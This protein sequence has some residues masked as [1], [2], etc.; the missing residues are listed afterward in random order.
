MTIRSIV[1]II[2][3]SAVVLCF[4]GESAAKD[5]WINVRT[6][7]FN[8]IGNAGEK[9]IRQ[10]ATKLEQFHES[11]QLLFA[12][13]NFNSAIQTNVVVFKSASS[14]RPYKPKRSDGKPDDG[15]AGYFQPGE[16]VNYITLSTEGE[17]EDTYGTIFHEYVHFLLNT[18]YGKSDVP[19]WF[20]EG[21]AEYYQTFKIA[22][23]QKITLG[24]IQYGHL[25]LLQQNN[26]IPLKQFFEVDNY[27]LHHNGNHSR[28]IFYAQAWALIHYMI[29]GNGGA[30][31]DALGK[32]LTLVMKD[33]EPEKAFRLAFNLNYAEMEE[34][35]KKYVEQRSFT[36]TVFTLKQK[37]IFDSQMSATLLSE[38]QANAYL[39]DLL[40]HTHDYP[41]AETHLTKALLLDPG[42]SVAHTSLG[43]VKMRQRNFPEAKKHL[44][45]AI[46]G[47]QKNHFAHFNYAYILSRE[48]MNEFGFVSG[49][50]PETSKKMRDSLRRAIEI[51]P[52]FAESY[53]LLAFVNMVSGEG[54]DES[55]VLLNKGLALQPGNQDYALL[56]AQIYLRQEKFDHA[57]AIAEKLAKTAADQ[58]MRHNAEQILNSINQYNNSKAA[59]ERQISELEAQGFK[60]PLILKRSSLSEAEIAKID[61]DRENNNLNRLLEKTQPGESRIVG[62][63]D[64]ITCVAD[65]VNY[66]V[67]TNKESLMLTSKD[68]QSLRLTV[69]HEGSQSYD[70][71]CDTKLNEELI[72]L[73]YRF[74]DPARPKTKGVLLSMDF[75]P[76]SFRM[77]T[78]EELAGAHTVIVE[79]GP[80]TGTAG[81]AEIAAAQRAEMEKQLRAM[82]LKNIERSLREPLAGETRVIGIVTKI[83]C[84]GKSMTFLVTAGKKPL[85]LKAPP[86]N[87][88]KLATFTPEAGEIQIGCG[89]SLP[90]VP[91][92]I[93]YLPDG[94]PKSEINGDLK[95]VEFVPKSFQLP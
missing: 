11:L 60:R 77:L 30:N 66:T 71:G 89:V 3:C 86:Q 70:I 28:S 18:N 35:L 20:N 36:G 85:R 33:I 29:Q 79:G 64:K 65:G 92:V 42:L 94:D 34:A 52:Q 21:L 17:K 55:L 6:K 19:P 43:L 23:N 87:E 24:D 68:F 81:N 2:W 93:T 76:K 15:I 90:D 47:D 51:N 50:S 45:K 74:A 26:L 62:Y 91:A 84:A 14:Y 54:L 72:V 82:F 57:R 73:T 39:G 31:N 41:A 13:V 46:A 4:A 27:S 95:A 7:N 67:R 78:A 40:Y 59:Q 8:L 22:E 37:L 10:V 9:E 5:E 38:A 25:R 32:F 16:D 75:V 69:L 48:S 12:K 88:L 53:H 56:A 83:E 63:I 58:P 44:E 49:F 1:L 80:P 61:A